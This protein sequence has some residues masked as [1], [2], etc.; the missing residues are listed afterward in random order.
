M[1][2]VILFIGILFTFSALGQKS[3]PF[4]KGGLH[5]L[6]NEEGEI[7]TEP[8]FLDI[9]FFRIVGHCDYMI[10]QSQDS[11]YGVIDKRGE[12]VLSPSAESKDYIQ[13]EN[14][15]FLWI[16]K[17]ISFKE[18][19]IYS[20]SGKRYID[21][22]KKGMTTYLVETLG[23]NPY[24]LLV[25]NK[26]ESTNPRYDYTLYNQSGKIVFQKTLSTNTGS[27]KYYAGAKKGFPLFFFFNRANESSIFFDEQGNVTSMAAYEAKHGKA[28]DR[29][30]TGADASVGP[31]SRRKEQ[32]SPQTTIQYSDITVVENWE[33]RAYATAKN[34]EGKL[35]L[36]R[37]NEVIIP[38]EFESIKRYSKRSNYVFAINP[39]GKTGLYN[40]SGKEILKPIF[41]NINIPHSSS[42]LFEVEL[43]NRYTGYA[44]YKGNIFLPKGVY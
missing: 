36:I 31:P 18:Y 13:F 34:N 17:D 27:L 11:L 39:E 42:R 33:N 44:D 16:Y 22:S 14:K 25:Q 38:F 19:Q 20:I 4:S 35:G 28:S 5:G 6:V 9:S 29:L 12:V 15:N 21:F 10:F 7:I 2:N 23:T 1:R 26:E 32:K 30:Y 43:D 41:K 3:Y 37:N 24:F 8:Q 40:M